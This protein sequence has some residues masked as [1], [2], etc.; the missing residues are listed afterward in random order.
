MQTVKNVFLWPGH[1]WL[2]KGFEA[3]FTTLIELA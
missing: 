3:W 1:D 2:R